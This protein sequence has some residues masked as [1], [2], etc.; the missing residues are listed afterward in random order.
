MIKRNAYIERIK[1]FIES[2]KNSLKYRGKRVW[3]KSCPYPLLNVKLVF[4]FYV[5]S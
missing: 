4:E 1:P 5:R 3:T 2:V